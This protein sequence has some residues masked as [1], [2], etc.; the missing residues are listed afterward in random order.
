MNSAQATIVLRYLRRLGSRHPAGQPTDSELL[1]RFTATRDGAAFEELVQRHGPMVLGV[2]RSVLGHEQDA[3]DAFQATFLVLARQAGAIRRGQALPAFLY[4]VAHRVAVQTRAAACRRRVREQR[5]SERAP[6]DHFLDMTLR[7]LQRV[8]HEELRRLPE[9]YR[10]PLVLCY[11]EGHTQAEAAA[12]LG[13]NKATFRGRLDRG[14]ERLRRRLIQRGVAPAATLGAAELLLHPPAVTAALVGSVVGAAA[15]EATLTVASLAR[16]VSQSLSAMKVK[17]AVVVLLAVGL[18]AGAAVL[19]QQKPVAQQPEPPPLQGAGRQ[20]SRDQDRDLV[21]YGG[22]VLDPEGRPIRDARVY[23]FDSFPKKQA[24]PVRARTGADGRYRFCVAKADFDKTYSPEPW[25]ETPVVA[26]ADGYGLGLPGVVGDRLPPTDEM[27][28]QLLRD[29]VP[30]NGRILD[31]QGRPVAGAMVR[32]RGIRWPKSGDLKAF[33]EALESR[34]EGAPPQ[35]EMLFG[36]TDPYHGWDLDE[37]FPP[38]VTDAAGR[39]CIRGIGRERVADLLIAGPGIETKYVYALTRPCK[40]IEV[41][42]RKGDDGPLKVTFYRMTHYGATFDHVA[43]PSKPIVGVVRDRDTGKP[44]PGAVVQSVALAG[45]FSDERTIFRAVSDESGRYRLTGMPRGKG[46]VLEAAPPD[47]QPYLLSRLDVGNSPGLEPVTVDFA[48]KRGVWISGKVTDKVTG[49]PVPCTFQYFALDDNTSLKE[50][51]GFTSQFHDRNPSPEGV[52]RVVGLPGRGLIA[53]RATEDRYLTG[54]GADRIPGRKGTAPFPTVPY[55]C[56]PE[57]FHAVAAVNAGRAAVAVTC[58][59]VLDPGRALVGTIRGP[60]DKPLAGVISHGLSHVGSWNYEP[61]RTSE[62]T[63]PAVQPGKS[64]RL[65]FVQEAKRLAATILV[66][67]DEK[68]PLAVKLEP[69]G[70][71]TGRLV[72]PEGKPEPEVWVMTMDGETITPEGVVPP[73]LNAGQVIRPVQADK[74]G[75]FRVEGVVPGLKYHLCVFKRNYLMD[76][77]FGQDLTIK[78]GQTKDLGDVKVKPLE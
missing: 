1:A 77:A 55:L 26:I 27:I 73:D 25:K 28:V 33:V 52:F 68:G 4:E 34:K 30:V 21:T 74:D 57:Q 23:L 19:V 66:R 76:A 56:F 11:L 63:V 61:L 41:P 22:R 53:V 75:R 54:V 50:A 58:D 32:V 64:R 3:E 40:T 13:L 78:P 67:G 42:A 38:V 5:V 69:W 47:D 62:F 59:L 48:L 46:S 15:G 39:F 36:L 71:L 70:V 31:L 20:P 18:I 44:I 10:L 60:D 43:A 8:L 17:L 37:L 29:D 65:L 12:Q 6:A 35:N 16:D 51:P 72:G 2:C 24:L 9:R 45:S 14:R 49:K 7:D